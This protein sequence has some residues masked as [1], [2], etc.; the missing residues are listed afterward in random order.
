MTWC[1]RDLLATRGAVWLLF[2]LG[3]AMSGCAGLPSD[4]DVTRA[5]DV[6]RLD[7]PN[8][9]IVSVRVRDQGGGLEVSGRLQKRYAGRSPI[10]GH[11]HIEALDQNGVVLGQATTR[12]HRLNPKLGSSTFSQFLDVRAENVRTLRVVHHQG[13]DESSGI[14]VASAHRDL[15]DSSEPA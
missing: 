1:K 10:P 2:L 7:S 9:E 15:L 8:A 14:P 12:Y 13:P 11:L 4:S 3:G 6:Q 5:L